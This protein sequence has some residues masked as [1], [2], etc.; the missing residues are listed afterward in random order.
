MAGHPISKEEGFDA[1]K[2]GVTKVLESLHSD[3]GYVVNGIAHRMEDFLKQMT[4]GG[5]GKQK[6]KYVQDG[7]TSP[8]TQVMNGFLDQEHKTLTNQYNK[9]DGGADQTKAPLPNDLPAQ[10]PPSESTPQLSRE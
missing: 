3:E 2:G 1:I 8:E 5:D 9:G 10:A 4:V 6:P 7:T